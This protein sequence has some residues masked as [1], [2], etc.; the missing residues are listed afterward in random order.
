MKISI[1]IPVFK[2]ELII[3]KLLKK[4]KKELYNFSQ[5]FSYEIILV[6]DNG[7]DSCWSKIEKLK[8]K[9]K[10]IIGIA[11]VKNYGQHSA[12]MAGFR[13]CT[14]DYIITM[15]DDL[16]HD[17]KY[18]G[19][20][21]TK[22]IKGHDVCYTNY[23]NRKHSSWKQYVSWWNN[24]IS[25]HLLNKPYELYLSSFRGIK[26]KI[27][28]DIIREKN[29][30][31][32]IDSVILK[33]T[34]NISSIS[35]KHRKRFEGESTYTVLKLIK[36]WVNMAGHS[37]IFPLRFSSFFVI[38]FLIILNMKKKNNIEQFKIIKKI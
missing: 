28:N 13:Y 27:V 17:P 3:E 20:L 6:N 29:P 2:S 16:Q 15:D 5:P 8:K 35:I 19:K 24:I 36:L 14:G 26:K 33:L 21:V 32:Y 30:S 37:T 7:I 23:T 4:L 34:S 11:L 38:I 12:I 25:S 9:F 10:N 18:I 1:I 22:L 31:I